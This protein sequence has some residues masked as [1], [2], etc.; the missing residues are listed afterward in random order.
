M[1]TTLAAPA[2]ALAAAA[3]I[4]SPRALAA[5][6]GCGPQAARTIAQSP[7]ARVYES[8]GNVYGCTDQGGGRVLLGSAGA[9]E[10]G[11]HIAPVA[12]AGVVVAYGSETC[13]IDTGSTLV[14]TRRLAGG[15][16][17]AQ[18]PATDGAVAPESYQSVDSLVVIADGA[19]AWIATANSL[20]RRAP[21]VQVHSWSSAG[22]QLLDSGLGVRTG[23]LRLRGSTLSWQHGDSVRTATLS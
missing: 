1:L 8:A 17:L 22:F 19:T 20:A 23:S 13:G 2:C 9:C 16:I 7:L 4:G 6:P 15:R 3:V 18:N 10:R 5:G 14:V 21:V 11:A 12:I